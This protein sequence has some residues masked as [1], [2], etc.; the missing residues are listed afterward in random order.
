MSVIDDKVTRRAQQLMD[1]ELKRSM[2]GLRL[3]NNPR[4]FFM[5]Y[6][7]HH[8]SGL[9]VWGRYGAVFNTERVR[10]CDLYVECRVGSYRL[11]QT[12]DGGL[13]QD[14]EDRESY[15]WLVGPQD[16]DPVAVRYAFWKLSQLKYQEALQ[17]YYDKRKILV[18]QR[19]KANANSLSRERK[20]IKNTEVQPIKFS[21]ARWEGFVRQ[22]SGLFSKY[23]KLVDPYV[24]IRGLN[25]VRVFVNSEGTKFIAQETFY[26]VIIKAWYLTTEGV[27]LDAARYFYARDAADLPKL[28]TV[29]ATI[30]DLASD[31]SSLARAKPLEPYAGPALLSGTATGLLFHEAIGHRLEG[32][33]MISRSEGQ[34]FTR[35][36]GQRILPE[37]VDMIDDPT[38]ADWNGQPLYGHYLIDDEGVPAQRVELVKKGVLKSFLL[39]RAGVPGFKR[40]N[41]H[42]RHE[43]FQDP[44]ARMANLIIEAEDRLRWDQLKEQ[45]LAE[46]KRRRLPHGIVVKRVSSGETAT[47][48]YEFQ[49][50][51]GVPTEVYTVDPKSGR[52]HRVR[53]VNFIGT[54]LAAIQR[55]RSFGEDYEVDNSYCYAESG[56][57]PVST[58]APAMLVDELELQR[59]A[60]RLYRAPVLKI[61]PMPTR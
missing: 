50:F 36:V 40:S 24:R 12:V 10:S 22:A 42:G 48:H 52:E 25:K 39:S 56:S 2:Q 26:E 5:S 58:V 14:H 60:T 11:D 18:D 49:A 47:S 27:Y 44:M 30:D 28:S 7:L 57:V 53:D 13:E 3:A 34:T 1:A 54:P 4:P 38:L 19:L 8:S 29:E 6:L 55:I 20:V 43:R 17:D 33:R 51:K 46:V 32:E 16:L 41:G 61:P 21:E 31:L 59:S 15:T 9:D 37:Q 23:K 35:K 45:M